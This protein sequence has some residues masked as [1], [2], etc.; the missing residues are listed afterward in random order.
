MAEQSWTD[1]PLVVDTT[2]IKAVHFYELMDAINAWET[3]YDIA[4]TSWTQDEPDSSD[5]IDDV[6]VDEMQ[7]ALDALYTLT[8][9]ST[10]EWTTVNNDDEIVATGVI[11]EVRTNMNWM[12]D[13]RCYLCDTCDT[14]TCTC[15][16]TCYNQSCAICNMTCYGQS[17]S[18]C[19]GCNQDSGKGCTGCD[20]ECY[21]SLG[22]GAACYNA[23]YWAVCT[24]CHSVCYEDSCTK[25]DGTNYRYPWT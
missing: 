16:N 1:D 8:D 11:P 10:F 17:C 23:I 18:I 6:S 7:D 2:K 4:N 3:A 15:E 25:C 9:S 5:K 22:C 20:G 24:G 12:Q 19:Y 14:E 21:A 13:N